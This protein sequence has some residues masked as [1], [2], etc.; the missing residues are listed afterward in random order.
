MRTRLTFLAAL[1]VMATLVTIA[2]VPLA[3]AAGTDLESTYIE[4][5][6][7]L[8]DPGSHLWDE[9]SPVEVVMSG[10]AIVRPM[11][12][13]PS[14]SSVQIR[15]INNGEWIA[16]RIDWDDATLN[17]GLGYD[18]FKDGVAIQLPVAGGLPFVCMGLSADTVNILHWRSDFQA[19]IARGEGPTTLNMNDGAQAGYFP[20]DIRDVPEYRSAYGAGNP[21]AALQKVSPV[22]NLMAGGFST[23]TTLDE[24]QVV[25]WAAWDD[26]RWSAVIA[27]PMSAGSDNEPVLA[28]GDETSVAIAVWDGG[29]GDISG[30]KTVSSWVSLGVEGPAGEAAAAPAAAEPATAAEPAIAPEPA[31]AP[32]PAATPEPA[33]AAGEDRQEPE[34]PAEPGQLGPGGVQWFLVGIVATIVLGG[35]AL[36]VFGLPSGRRRT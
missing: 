17:D 32:E 16:F 18:A 9:A 20:F 6:L 22:E 26:G 8:A 14:V 23:L 34:T 33:A 10:Q 19:D 30:K 28:A 5:D 25:G 3:A 21:I 2:G 27:R 24:S 13:D 11:A 15:S 7:P 1:L 12:P 35:G 29:R 36:M 31:T 4:G